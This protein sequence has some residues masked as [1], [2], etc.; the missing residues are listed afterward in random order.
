[1]LLIFTFAK[2]AFR[3]FF[4]KP[5]KKPKNELDKKAI[6]MWPIGWSELP[7]YIFVIIGKTKETHTTKKQGIIT[8][9]T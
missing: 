5:I 2:I 1:M 8:S 9:L 6:S 4:L 3:S 7:I